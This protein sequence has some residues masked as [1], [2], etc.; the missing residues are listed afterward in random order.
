[1]AT[2]WRVH[3][4]LLSPFLTFPL[5]D[6]IAAVQRG[7]QA[8]RALTREEIKA[9]LAEGEEAADDGQEEAADEEAEADEEDGNDDEA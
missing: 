4:T 8:R 6:R 1:M 3:S 9:A 7:K 5:A 2:I